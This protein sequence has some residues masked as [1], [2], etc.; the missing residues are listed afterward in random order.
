M[1]NPYVC[2]VATREN[3]EARLLL[4]YEADFYSHRVLFDADPV[5]EGVVIHRIGHRDAVT[6]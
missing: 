6:R 3:I 2:S 4:V 1:Y 5:D